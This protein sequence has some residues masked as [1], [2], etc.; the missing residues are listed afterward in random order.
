[1]FDD[2]HRWMASWNLFPDTGEHSYE[3]AVVA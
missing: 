2:T 1:M 3:T